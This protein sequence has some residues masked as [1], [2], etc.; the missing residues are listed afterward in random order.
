MYRR[1]LAARLKS[2]EGR[3]CDWKLGSQN[4][5]IVIYPSGRL[6]EES[7]LQAIK[8]DLL[9][10]S[11]PAIHLAHDFIPCIRTKEKLS[12]RLVGSEKHASAQ[13][14]QRRYKQKV[15]KKQ[16]AQTVEGECAVGRTG[17]PVV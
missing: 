4:T 12:G 7:K 3:D 1:L 11:Q 8:P 14:G 6:V 5:S 13:H 17:R 16:V 9:Q 2:P 10:T 15:E